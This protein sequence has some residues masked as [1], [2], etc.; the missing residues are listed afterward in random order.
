VRRILSIDGGGIKGVFPASFLA[1]IEDAVGDRVS[2]YFDLI[3]GTST[4]GII[5]LG[6]GLGWS[7][8]ELLAFYEELGPRIFKGAP[9][10]RGL[11]WLFRA[12]YDPSPLHE[13]LV[14]QF[15]DRRIGESTTRLVIPSVNLENGKVHLYKTAHDPRFETDYKC[16]AVEVARATSAAPAYFPSYASPA[17][18][19]LVDG[20]VWANNP[21]AVA[22]VE[23]VGVLEWSRAE[24]AV[25]SLGCTTEPFDVKWARRRALGLGYWGLRATE[26]FMA[27]QAHAALGM[28]QHL[29]GKEN[30]VRFNPVMPRGRF[31][32]DLTRETQALRGLGAT[33]AREALPQLR[34]VFFAEPADHFVPFHRLEAID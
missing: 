5:A 28:A 1:T 31:K 4:G 15:G 27:A 2:N 14:E 10:L 11:P 17:G 25:L 20:G 12:K 6:L 21:V 8:A 32:L 33:E 24:T 13:A 30:V 9:Y 26:L 29:L 23:A 16:T 34:R 7:A 22:A 18:T 3:V 19:P